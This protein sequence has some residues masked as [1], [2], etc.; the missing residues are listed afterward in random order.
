MYIKGPTL[1]ETF[2]EVTNCIASEGRPVAN[3][4][5]NKSRKMGNFLVRYASRVIIYDGRAVIRLATDLV[6]I[7]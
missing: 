6:V 3:L 1:K 5:N 4:I 2:L 7:G